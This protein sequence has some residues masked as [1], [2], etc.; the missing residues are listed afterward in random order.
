MT[1][2]VTSRDGTAIGYRRLGQGPGVVVLHGAFESSE[3]HRELAE[4]LADAFTVTL[5]DRRGRGLS[6]PFG[7][8]PGVQQEVE[9]LD[10]LLSESGARRVVGIS[11]GAI[12]CLHAALALPALEK[13]VIFEPPLVLPRGA[14][15]LVARCDRELAEG[16]TAAALVT[17]M[18]ASR[19]GPAVFDFAP[20]CLLEA[21]AGAMLRGEERGAGPD[22]MTVRKLAP[23]LRF[24]F[25][26]ALA[27]DGQLERFEAIRAALLLL[28]GSRSP[29]F[30]KASLDGLHEILPAARRAVLP[31]L[32][33][34]ALGNANRGG[35]PARAAE[36]LR[37]FLG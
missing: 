14:A 37:R 19:M 5:P 27:T 13:A 9:D 20:R 12:V 8:H 35:K 4:A 22:A 3:S 15:A 10:A 29:A 23:T 1:G 25:A 6:G 16:R 32:G 17:A 28:G 11:S 2:A 34:G 24:D 30:L 31:G 18:K 36:A 7:D 33:H 21:L 26:L